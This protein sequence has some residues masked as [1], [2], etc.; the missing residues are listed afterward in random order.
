MNNEHGVIFE[1]DFLLACCKLM[2]EQRNA[3]RDLVEDGLKTE[4]S[5]EFKI[6][7]V[8]EELDKIIPQ[9]TKKPILAKTSNSINTTVEEDLEGIEFVTSVSA[10]SKKRKVKVSEVKNEKKPAKRARKERVKAKEVPTL[11]SVN[12]DIERLEESNLSENEA[13]SSEML[14]AIEQM[15]EA[16]TQEPF[17]NAQP[18]VPN[19][20]NAAQGNVD[21]EV[22]E[23]MNDLSNLAKEIQDNLSEADLSVS[24]G[25][26]SS[27]GVDIDN[28]STS[29]NG[30]NEVE[31]M[32]SLAS[33]IVKEAPK[34]GR[35][36]TRATDSSKKASATKKI[37]AEVCDICNQ[38]F[39]NA[40]GLFIHKSRMHKD[41]NSPSVKAC[42]VD[43][44][45][46]KSAEHGLELEEVSK[47]T[48]SGGEADKTAELG[49]ELEEAAETSEG[50]A[51]K[52]DSDLVRRNLFMDNIESDNEDEELEIIDFVK[53]PVIEK[54][55]SVEDLRKKSPYFQGQGKGM[56]EQCSIQVKEMFEK[57]I[58]FLP[59]WK[60]R[61]T[62]IDKGN[63][64]QNK[65]TNFLTPAPDT[66]ILRSG[67]AV[68]E[69]LRL[70]GEPMQVLETLGQKMK[71]KEKNWTSYKENYLK[72]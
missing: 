26:D 37:A 52:S 2:A 43:L 66:I 11:S 28:I 23:V 48:E 34:R 20:E 21:Q 65:I 19:R 22:D 71:L 29:F 36:R 55:L 3:F 25:S 9:L 39:L 16:L 63:G 44:K 32:P 35:G 64:Q 15:E 72:Y 5:N 67:V 13:S 41:V 45:P 10:E 51:D 4:T 12:D 7:S 17:S 38:S 56:L 70:K 50:E 6:E 30:A 54:G 53:K 68:L 46:I 61:K 47:I 8:K 27:F 69:Y 14:D 49:P 42:K 60:M 24:V 58:K 1:V 40:K 62:V 18:Q 33:E 59:G 57:D 31:E